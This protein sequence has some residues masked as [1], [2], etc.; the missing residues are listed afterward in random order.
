MSFVVAPIG[1]FCLT[2]ALLSWQRRASQVERAAPTRERIE[3]EVGAAAE[4]LMAALPTRAVDTTSPP[5]AANISPL[6]PEPQP[7]QPVLENKDAAQTATNRLPARLTFQHA[8]GTPRREALVFNESI[9]PLDISLT[10]KNE[11]TGKYGQVQFSIEPHAIKR[12]GLHDDLNIESGDEVT[13]Q[14]Q[15]YGEVA[16]TAP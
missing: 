11:A 1:A 13:L 4:P 9:N 6:A 2:F 10:V 15:S 7:A 3:S 16:S 8:S 14:G 12:F 5:A